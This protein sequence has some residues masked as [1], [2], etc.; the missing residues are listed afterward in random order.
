MKR[1]ST[2]TALLAGIVLT[3]AGALAQSPSQRLE[4]DRKG[5][6]IVL[7]PYAPNILRVTISLKRDP[8]LAS[9]GYGFIAE[10]AASG[11]NAS[12]TPQADVYKS[13]RMAVTVE[14]E[15]DSSWGDTGKYFSPSAP[16]GRPLLRRTMSI[17]TAWART[18]RD[19]S[20]I[21]AMRS[22]AGKITWPRPDRAVACLSS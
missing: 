15:H 12:Q 13:D 20:T 2:V 4:L 8:A 7:E 21:A 14:R 17:T 11:W 22:A 16:W 1:F 6:T 19:S 3:A 10:P 18:R 9:P 5:E